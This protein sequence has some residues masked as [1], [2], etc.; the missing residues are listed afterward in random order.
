[1]SYVVVCLY[2][3]YI[4]NNMIQTI[5]IQVTPD[6]AADMNALRKT[7][8]QKLSIGPHQINDIRISKRSID[9]RSR[10]ILVNL[11]LICACK[12][13]K[14]IPSPTLVFNPQDVSHKPEVHIIGAGP[15]GLFAALRLIELGYKP[16][17]FERGKD[18]S[19][20]KRD[21]ALLNRN[22]ALNPDSN[23]CFG[24]GGAGTFSDG[25]LYTRSKKKGDNKR[26]LELFVIHGASPDILIDAHPHIG[27]DKLPQVIQNMRETIRSWGGEVHFD[28]KITGVRSQD[29]SITHIV[30]NGTDIPVQQVL[31]ATGHSARDIY[32]MLHEHGIELE[33]KAFAMGVRAEHPQEMIDYNQYHGNTSDALPAASYSLVHQ[34]EGRGVYSFCMCPGGI[35]VPSATEQQQTV[36]NGMS[37]SQRNSPFANSGIAVELRVEDFVEFAEHGVLAGLKYQEYLETLAYRNGGHNQIAP[38]QTIRDFIQKR[39]SK[40]LPECSYVPGVVSSP[41]HFWLP[42]HISNRL[43][44]A[45]IA[46]DRK[47]RGYASEEGIVVGVESRTSSPVRIPRN[48]E[49]LTHVRIQNLYPCGEGSGYAGGIV[50][51]AIDGINCAEKISDL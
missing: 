33:A 25:K 26:V 11:E 18:I 22:E 42:E 49:T 32:Y 20:R 39:L 38:A 41:M 5:S 8:A 16:I 3:H 7:A 45:F 12:H 17:V 34:V 28:S 23:Y 50:S 2:F 44:E 40:Q 19:G 47:I 6:I 9:A 15:A 24:E 35:I 27:T 30:C 21:V 14:K 4:L 51:S 46:F 48:A 37:N 31:L 13:T 43:R 36:V 1:M 29:N 10:N